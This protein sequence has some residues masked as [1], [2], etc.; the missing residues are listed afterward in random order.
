MSNKTEG[1][2]PSAPSLKTRPPPSRRASWWRS[3]GGWRDKGDRPRH[4]PPPIRDRHLRG[5]GAV[6]WNDDGEMVRRPAR[7]RV[8]ARGTDRDR[9]RGAKVPTRDPE[10]TAR[11][12]ELARQ[13]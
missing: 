10:I 7:E 3:C 12:G 11:S 6:R 9:G 5:A 1:T 8:E 4:A 13:R 2:P